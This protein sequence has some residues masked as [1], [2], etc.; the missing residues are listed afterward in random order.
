MFFLRIYKSRGQE[1]K[2][3]YANIRFLPAAWK[4]KYYCFTLQV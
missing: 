2:V 3:S 4:E 1:P